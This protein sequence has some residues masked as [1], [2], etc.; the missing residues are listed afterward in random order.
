MVYGLT[1]VLILIIPLIG[2]AV[3]VYNLIRGPNMALTRG[4]VVAATALNIF[5]IANGGGL[6]GWADQM[7]TFAIDIARA[8]ISSN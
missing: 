1:F 3:L 4:A 8:N 5:A 2:F 7:N 6:G